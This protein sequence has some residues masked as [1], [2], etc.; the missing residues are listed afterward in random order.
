MNQLSCT[1]C[2]LTDGF[3]DI[4]SMRIVAHLIVFTFREHDKGPE[5]F[6]R[7][8]ETLIEHGCKFQL[9]VLGEQYQEIPAVFS[10][11]KPKLKA[12]PDCTLLDWGFVSKSR[13]YE[14]LSRAHV[15]VST[16]LHEFYGVSM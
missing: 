5:S 1:S 6:F 4:E 16:A 3:Y 2:G 10:E 13:F 14:I 11:I 9:S 8:I 15:V 12:Y 7:V